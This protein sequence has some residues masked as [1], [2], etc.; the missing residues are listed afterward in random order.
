MCIQNVGN[1][2]L[3][4]GVK[5]QLWPPFFAKAK[6]RRWQPASIAC[7]LNPVLLFPLPHKIRAGSHIPSADE[8]NHVVFWGL[9][10]KALTLLDCWLWRNQSLWHW[11]NLA[12]SGKGEASLQQPGRTSHQSGRRRQP[13]EITLPRSE[14]AHSGPEL[15]HSWCVS[16]PQASM[17]DLKA[18]GVIMFCRNT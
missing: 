16:E 9:S 10:W 11:N 3:S 2:T 17:N 8:S 18:P 14:P 5:R 6:L 13:P 1:Y 15:L 7:L 4:N 12:N